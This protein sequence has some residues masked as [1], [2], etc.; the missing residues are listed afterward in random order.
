VGRYPRAVLSGARVV[1]APSGRQFEIASGDRRACVVE[2]GG[3][4]RTYS[5]GGRE[6]LDGYGEDEMCRSARGQCLVPWPNRIADGSYE[7]AGVR[8]Q[9]ALNEPER[10]TAIHG[11]GSWANWT[12]AERAGDRVT[13][14]LRLHP[15]PGYPHSLALV[16]DYRVDASGLTVRTTATNVGLTA[17]PYGAGAHPYLSVGTPS[18]DSIVLRAPGR[19]RLIG[20][21]RGIPT[22]AEAVDA[23][24]YDFRERRPIGS[25]KLDT[26]FGDLERD[27]DGRARVRLAAPDGAVSA[28]LWLDEHYRYLMLFTGDPLPDVDRRS[29]GIEPMTC[30]PNAFQSGDGLVILEPGESFAASWGIESS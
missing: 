20:D 27:L 14:E 22:G 16:V 2:V 11:L 8:Q 15:Q 1:T 4:L 28:T 18:V 12:V 17:C 13:L 7:F 26:A 25:L 21:A 30:A 6:V 9:L 10:Q 5:V 24:E 3:G 19:T 23:S 29:L